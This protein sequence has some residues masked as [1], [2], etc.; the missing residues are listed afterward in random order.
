MR[1]GILVTDGG[2]HPADKWAAETA[3]EIMSLVKVEDN[4]ASPEAVAVRKAKPRLEL[5]IADALEKHHQAH[6]D[7]EKQCLETEGDC[8]LN[9]DYDQC[10]ENFKAAVE[11][12][13]TA[14]RAYGEPF[15]SAFSSENGQALVANAIRVHF[16][17]A[18]HVE[19]SWHADSKLQPGVQAS[20][21]VAH[22][23][24]RVHG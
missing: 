5:D 12:V 8:R 3:A 17:S 16:A 1:V 19:R 11:A 13:V 6:I 9:H 18:A 7:R 23:R 22:F 21:D 10:P 15:L 24:R 20:P 2:P 4:S 14:A